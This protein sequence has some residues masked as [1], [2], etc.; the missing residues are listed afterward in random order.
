MDHTGGG[1]ETFQL[2]QTSSSMAETQKSVVPVSKER[3]IS[4]QEEKELRRVFD[5][6][7]DYSAKSKL[8]EE[9]KELEVWIQNAKNKHT[10]TMAK[11]TM[12]ASN[13]EKYEASLND[14]YSRID[15]LRQN[16]AA[17]ENKPD[18]KISCT[19]VTAMYKFLNHKISKDA[20][21]EL[22]WEVDEDLDR[23]IN[24]S[25]FRLMFARNISDKSGLEP[26][27]MY[28]LTQFLIYDHNQNGLVSVDETMHILYARF[29]RTKMELKLKELFGEDMHET[30]REGGE[31]PFSKYI[32]A[33]EKIQV[34]TFYGTTKG[35]ISAMKDTYRKKI[36]SGTTKS[37]GDKSQSR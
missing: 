20:I 33:V 23:M 10:L 17:I 21:E 13:L 25:E 12:V 30:G 18:K 2:T 14:T 31:I 24:W 26:S 8:E 32:N 37:H 19:D 1:G 7:C 27:R 15:K 22:V 34:Q 29:G 16:V 6:L 36:L 35:R 4:V 28:N 11:G 9:V 3:L 5:F